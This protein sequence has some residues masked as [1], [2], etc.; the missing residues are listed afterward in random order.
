MEKSPLGI[1]FPGRAVAELCHGGIT[2]LS[3]GRSPETLLCEI[4]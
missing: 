4:L 1:S 2:L 3:E